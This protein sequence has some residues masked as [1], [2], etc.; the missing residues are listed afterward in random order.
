MKLKLDISCKSLNKYREELCGDQVKYRETDDSGILVVADGMGNGVKANILSTLTASIL[1]NML[2]NGS[3]L[4]EALET[5][6]RTLPVCPTRK[7]AYSTFMAL[8]I[9]ENGETYIAE[10]DS[11]GCLFLREGKVTELPFKE[12]NINGR[13]IRECRIQARE[14]DMF[15]LL[16]DGVINAGLGLS[17]SLGWGIENAGRWVEDN[18]TDT[19]L[20]SQIASGILD[21]C[22]LLYQN[23]PGDDCTAAVVRVIKKKTVK[24]LTGPPSSPDKDEE[25]VQRFMAMD[26]QAVLCG[27]TT[28]TIVSR[29]LQRPL[30]VSLEYFDV[31]IPPMAKM[32]GMKLVTEGIVTLN[33]VLQLVN[34]YNAGNVDS[35][36]YQ[37]LQKKDGASQ[38]ARLL[39]EEC[40][41]VRMIV[42]KTMNEAYQNP[43]LPIE[44]NLRMIL[45]ERLQTALEKAGKT[46]TIQYV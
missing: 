26:G 44:F 23:Q 32:E 37:E 29:V 10:Y 20:P 35:A 6:A 11:P 36:F 9:Y 15:I 22:D 41:D 3:P 45:V 31:D 30:E 42:G 2:Y 5:V 13:I 39:L 46:V 40:T 1:G 18:Y 25:I 38:L 24:I 33:R 12:R 27:G 28:A 7:M 34:K 21:Q 16:T 8:Q 17:N 43:M 19:V 14:D 4:D